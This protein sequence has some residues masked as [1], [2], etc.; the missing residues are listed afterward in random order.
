MSEVKAE[1]RKEKC[2]NCTK[3]VNFCNLSLV[4]PGRTNSTHS[5]FEAVFLAYCELIDLHTVQQETER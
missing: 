2:E 5:E 4:L 3:Q 1:S